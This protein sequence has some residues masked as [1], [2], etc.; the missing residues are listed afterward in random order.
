VNMRECGLQFAVKL[1]FWHLPNHFL[2]QLGG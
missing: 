2:P 1:K